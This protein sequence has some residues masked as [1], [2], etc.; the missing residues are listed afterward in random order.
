MRENVANNLN[1]RGICVCGQHG[2]RRFRTQEYSPA[3]VEGWK[4]E[5]FVETEPRK[6]VIGWGGA[7]GKGISDNDSL[8]DRCCRYRVGA[9]WFKATKSGLTRSQKKFWNVCPSNRVRL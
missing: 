7:L 6:S 9:C 2:A 8:W 3:I 1:R 5:G 4:E